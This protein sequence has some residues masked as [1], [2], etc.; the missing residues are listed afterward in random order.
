MGGRRVD[1]STKSMGEAKVLW[2]STPHAASCQQ[3]QQNQNQNQNQGQDGKDLVLR[4]RVFWREG[5]GHGSPSAW[6]CL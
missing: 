6:V 2:A 4:R 3:H 5:K 1:I